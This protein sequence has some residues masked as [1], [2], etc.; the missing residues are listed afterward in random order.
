MFSKNI[1]QI[2]ACLI[3]ILGCNV[4][5]DEE[6]L[7]TFDRPT[8]WG[9][10]NDEV[11]L[12][13]FEAEEKF[14]DI[15]KVGPTDKPD[16]NDY[17]YTSNNVKSLHFVAESGGYSRKISGI[18]LQRTVMREFSRFDY[19]TL[20]DGI[21]IGINKIT[22]ASDSVFIKRLY[23]PRNKS[24][25][26]EL[27]RS[28]IDSLIRAPFDESYYNLISKTIFV[29]NDCGKIQS[30]EELRETPY[31]DSE[32]KY[33]NIYTYNENCNL[34]RKESRNEQGQITNLNTYQYDNGVRSIAKEWFP[35]GNYIFQ[36]R[37]ATILK[38]SSYEYAPSSS[39]W[40]KRTEKR[41]VIH[42]ETGDTIFNWTEYFILEKRISE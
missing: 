23:T 24:F 6:L 33:T 30:S 18:A 12:R 39:D 28:N 36:D 16:L 13:S 11:Y 41:E 10:L 17:D 42:L 26:R 20:D 29:I 5:D 25:Y 9:N 35:M 2:I 34:T 38:S 21:L 4:S 37:Y 3:F 22:A 31:N 14:G 40:T 8:L 32:T 1:F 27:F 7:L 19:L 15:V